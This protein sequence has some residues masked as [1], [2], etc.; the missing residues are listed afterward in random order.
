MHRTA[1]QIVRLGLGTAMLPGQIKKYL[2]HTAKL[3]L[4]QVVIFI[5]CGATPL[6]VN[7]THSMHT[8]DR[9]VPIRSSDRIITV[10]IFHPSGLRGYALF[11]AGRHMPD[12]LTKIP[13]RL[14]YSGKL[15]HIRTGTN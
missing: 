7:Y 2:P 8:T 10:K 3:L 11:K 9:T 6:G 13:L 14:P 12:F 4:G 15:K 5:T 1:Q